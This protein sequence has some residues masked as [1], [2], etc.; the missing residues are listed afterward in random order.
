MSTIYETTHKTIILDE[1]DWFQLEAV[2]YLFVKSKNNKET[3]LI[4]K[5]W[6]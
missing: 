5:G 1:E 6:N 4:R 3:V 2:G